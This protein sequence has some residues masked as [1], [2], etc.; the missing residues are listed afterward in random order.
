[1]AYRARVL[2]DLKP[3]TYAWY[4]N[5]HTLGGKAGAPNPALMISVNDEAT[6][7]LVDALSHSPLWKSTLVVVVEDDPQD[8]SDHVDYHRS[9][10]VMASPWIKR[11]YV[12]HTHFD[13]P[14]VH[15]LFAHIF[16]LPYNNQTVADAA[17]PL[18]LFTSTPD[19]TPF[20]YKPRS[21]ADLSCNPAGSKLA[22]EAEKWDFSEPD[23]QPGLSDQVWRMVHD[24]EK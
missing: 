11:G 12:S 24:G 14:A 15:K 23:D 13:I 7:M 5:D 18:D 3:F 10:A 22:E 1:M 4:V 19:Y 2:C 21:Y 17:L 6:G 20:S 8:G 9:I 16:G